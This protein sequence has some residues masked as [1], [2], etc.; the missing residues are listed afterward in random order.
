MDADSNIP[1]RNGEQE[2]GRMVQPFNVSFSASAD[3]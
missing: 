3:P 1:R 2:A